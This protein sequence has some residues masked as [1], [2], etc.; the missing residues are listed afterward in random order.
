MSLL[1]VLGL[2][3]VLAVTAPLVGADTRYPGA[4]P[5]PDRPR[6]EKRYRLPR[7]TATR[8]AVRRDQLGRTT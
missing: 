4:A 6:A 1:I 3:L 7:G 2:L 8:F 5:R